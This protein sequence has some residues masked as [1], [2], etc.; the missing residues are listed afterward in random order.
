MVKEEGVVT[1]A[2]QS[3]AWVKTVRTSAC[4]A[5]KAKD[6]CEILNSKDS[7]H[8]EVRNI[9]NAGK[10]DRVVVGV[11]TRPLLVLTFML[12][13]FPIFLLLIGAVAGKNLAF[14]LKTDQNLTSILFG[15][16]L[17]FIAVFIIK[18]INNNVAKNQKY[19]PFLVK[20]LKKNNS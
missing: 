11:Q 4:D 15:F 17:F 19:R 13:V 14:L 2:S 12:Y 1:S 9:L 5:C 6:N 20:I 8:F 3:T 10:G 16:I 7:M 18:K